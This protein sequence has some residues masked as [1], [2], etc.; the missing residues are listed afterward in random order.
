MIF[1]NYKS[2]NKYKKKIIKHANN[3]T[4]KYV[5]VKSFTVMKIIETISVTII[6]VTIFL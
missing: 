2:Y 5:T 6:I 4:K 3:K 1:T